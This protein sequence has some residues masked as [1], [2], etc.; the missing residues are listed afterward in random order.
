M[1]KEMGMEGK[2][3]L[4]IQNKINEEFGSNAVKADNRWGI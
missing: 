4:D 2:S 1:I 3:A